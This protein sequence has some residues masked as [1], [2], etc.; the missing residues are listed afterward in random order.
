MARLRATDSIPRV[1]TKAG[2]PTWAINT[3]LTSPTAS[4][5][6]SPAAMP[7]HAA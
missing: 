1:V 7:T 4:E 3:P 5:A 2:I 6:T